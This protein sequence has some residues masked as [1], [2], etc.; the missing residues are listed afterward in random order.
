MTTPARSVIIDGVMG[1][2]AVKQTTDQYQ[3]FCD[4]DG[5]LVEL[6]GGIN[7]AIY[8][9]P[10]PGASTRY[11]KAQADA[12]EALNG[13]PLKQE[14]VDSKHENFLKPVRDFMMRVMTTDRRFWM[15]LDWT[16]D[17]QE[18]WEYIKDFN[19]IV[20]SIPTDLQSVIGKKKWVKDNLGLSR[21]RVQIR[22]QKAPYA[23][24]EDKTGLLIDD[25][26]KNIKLFGEAG[27][28]TIHFTS[29]RQAIEA[30]KEY[31]FGRTAT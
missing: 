27:G 13:Q 10:R 15:N 1:K 28:E 21:N 31:G 11:I 8:N 9:D 17:G 22:Y 18:L 2:I 29:A 30:L 12:R 6:I 7:D 14:F 24:Y 5:V 25:F 3:I 19:P 20:L 23:Q 16:E 4:L 26:V